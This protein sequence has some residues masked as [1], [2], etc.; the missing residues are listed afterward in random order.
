MVMIEYV[1]VRLVI[2]TVCPDKPRGA[3]NG[4]DHP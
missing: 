3:P 1:V 2:Q 4:D